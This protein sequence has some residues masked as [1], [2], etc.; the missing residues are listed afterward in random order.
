MMGVDRRIGTK[1][2]RGM[3]MR[4]LGF[5]VTVGLSTC[6]AC[7]PVI[8]VF[9]QVLEQLSAEVAGQQ[10]PAAVDEREHARDDLVLCATRA[11]ERLHQR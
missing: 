6:G 9:E 1:T 3:F 2:F 5:L 11:G 7:L 8:P 4:D 10:N